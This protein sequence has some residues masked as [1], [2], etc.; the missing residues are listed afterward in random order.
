MKFYI[1]TAVTI[2]FFDIKDIFGISINNTEINPSGILKNKDVGKKGNHDLTNAEDV[3]YL[4]CE[5]PTKTKIKKT[6]NGL[7]SRII[8]RGKEIKASIINL[9]KP[10]KKNIIEHTNSTSF[11]DRPLPPLPPSPPSYC[12]NP[13][14]FCDTILKDNDKELGTK[15]IL[16]ESDYEEPRCGIKLSESDYEEP[17]FGN[18]LPKLTCIDLQNHMSSE[19]GIGKALKKYIHDEF[20]K[21]SELSELPELSELSELPELPEFSDNSTRGIDNSLSCIVKPL[22]TSDASTEESRS[23]L[24]IPNENDGKKITS[25]VTSQIQNNS[26]I[27][28]ENQPIHNKKTT[29]EM[30]STL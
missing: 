14:Y 13:I 3:E 30:E 9:F 29:S 2:F 25:Q 5:L 26:P 6:K 17:R 27:L 23:A 11:C 22:T 21:L 7:K 19:Q 20:S 12:S 15:G 4:E 8:N 1:L 28:E 18:K 10:Q 24:D 16:S